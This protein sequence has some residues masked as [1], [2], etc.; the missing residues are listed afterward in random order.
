MFRGP[1]GTICGPTATSAG[2]QG[3]LL[4]GHVLL[5]LAMVLA[6]LLYIRLE[7]PE[8]MRSNVRLG[9]LALVVIGNLALVRV[10]Y[11]LGGADFFVRA[12]A[13]AATLPYVAPTALAPLI[14]AILI[15]AGS[16]IFMALLISIFTGV[17][18]GNRVDLLVLTFLASMVAIFLGHDARRRGRVVSAAGAGGLTVAAFAA[19]VG[20]A[21]ETAWS[22]PWSGKWP[23]AW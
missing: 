14:V 9:L 20:F 12:G 15:D 2:C 13:W 8:T 1:P 6:S 16:G 7:D 5:V 4:F 3:L 19:L 22:T 23:P 21:Q 11:T 18:Y 10:V 17:I